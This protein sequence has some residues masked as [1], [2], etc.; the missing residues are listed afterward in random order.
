MEGLELN[1]PALIPKRVHDD[2]QILCASD[3]TRHD[4]I[5]GPIQENL[6]K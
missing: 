6:A 3:I 4:P 1:V 5:V 2:L